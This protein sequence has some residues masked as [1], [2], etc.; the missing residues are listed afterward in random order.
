M[1]YESYCTVGLHTYTSTYPAGTPTDRA[2]V[3]YDFISR[4]LIWPQEQFISD[5]LYTGTA[6]N[7]NGTAGDG[8]F[9]KRGPT[10]RDPIYI[11][12]IKDKPNPL[13]GCPAWRLYSSGTISDL[14]PGYAMNWYPQAPGDGGPTDDYRITLLN[15][16]V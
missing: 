16:C 10:Q 13:W 8:I 14:F 7:Y 1:D 11:G 5:V 6:M 15:R 2:K 9:I 3:W 12:T 4:F